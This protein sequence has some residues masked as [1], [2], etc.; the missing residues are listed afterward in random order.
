MTKTLLQRRARADRSFTPTTHT[1]PT[2][3]AFPVLPRLETPVDA[4]PIITCRPRI[5]LR[6]RA[7]HHGA[8]L[9]PVPAAVRAA[10]AACPDAESESAATATLFAAQ[11]PADAE[12]HVAKCHV[13][14]HGQ[15]H[16]PRKAT[17]PVPKS[18]L[19]RAV[20]VALCSAVVSHVAL[21]WVSAE[22][23]L[24]VPAPVAC[25]H[26]ATAVPPT[27]ALPAPKQ[28]AAAT[29]TAAAKLYAAP[30]SALQQ[31]DG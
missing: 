26:A 11:L 13:S 19:A 27:P 15:R 4:T 14:D 28:Y 25:Q 2:T 9:Q 5:S 29:T 20:P 3:P 18:N 6:G 10:P 22:H 23:R 1:A 30:E 8:E 31:G 12:C 21:R 16:P 24:P 17:A 7:A